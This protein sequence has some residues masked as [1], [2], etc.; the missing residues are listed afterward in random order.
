MSFEITQFDSALLD[1][2]AMAA[3][4]RLVVRY[5]GRITS[6][7]GDN[8]VFVRLNGATSGYT[9]IA[10]MDGHANG[11]EWE[12]R[13]L[14]VGRNGWSIDAD[15]SF[16][17]TIS[18][19]AGRKRVSYGLSSFCHADERVLG[20]TCQGFWETTTGTITDVSFWKAGPGAIVRNAVNLEY[21]DT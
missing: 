14:Y 20:Y 19:M 10:V 1:V 6:G 8:R 4:K 12:Q 17:M 7:G 18:L 13:G 3:A 5:D 9:S 15:F 11:G 2:T 21:Q 16:M